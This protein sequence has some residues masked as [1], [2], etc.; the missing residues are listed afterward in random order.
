MGKVSGKVTFRGE[1]VAQGLVLFAEREKNL[2]F[3]AKLDQEGT[4]RVK[5][6][7]GEGL[8]VGSYEVT[9]N[10]P[11]LDAPPIGST[12]RPAQ[13]PRFPNIPLKYRVATSSGLKLE[14]KEGENPFNIEMQ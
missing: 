11:V 3:T 6:A 12:M 8:P 9:V 13:V 10:P 1:P 7:E 4:Y 5:T 14:V 2:Y